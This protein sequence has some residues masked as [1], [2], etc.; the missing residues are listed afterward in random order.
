M[1]IPG[2]RFARGVD[3][4][5]NGVGPSNPVSWVDLNGDP[6]SMVLDDGVEYL[7]LAHAEVVNEADNTQWGAG[8]FRYDSTVYAEGRSTFRFTTFGGNDAS[9]GQVPAVFVV[10]GDGE[11]E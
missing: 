6:A 10:T 5:L 9:G 7:V 8:H 1:T 4:T 2:L 3:A 11:S